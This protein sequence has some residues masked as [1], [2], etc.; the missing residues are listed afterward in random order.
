MIGILSVMKY[1][2]NA[3]SLWGTE[4]NDS[5]SI[6]ENVYM[7]KYYFLEKHYLFY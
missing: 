2:I 4:V 7:R 1:N 5:E 6:F 3:L